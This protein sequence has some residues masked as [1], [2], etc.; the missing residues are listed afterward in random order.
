MASDSPEPTVPIPSSDRMSAPC[1]EPD[2]PLSDLPHALIKA[3]GSWHLDPALKAV[4][5]TQS[6]L[7]FLDYDGTLCPIVDRPQDAILSPSA[8]TIVR[9]TMAHVPTAI[10][11]GRDRSDVQALVGVD[12]L[13]YVGSHGFDADLP[14]HPS[15]APQVADATA[16]LDRVEEALRSSLASIDGA[17][18]ERKA[19]SIAAHY[20]LVDET[21]LSSFMKGVDAVLTHFPELTEKPGKKVR[22]LLPAVDWDKGKCVLALLDALGAADEGHCA[23][24]IGDD[25]TDEDAFRALRH[26]RPEMGGAGILVADPDDPENTD[27]RSAARWRVDS[28]DQVLCLLEVLASTVRKR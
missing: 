28:P 4:L 22:E 15:L 24:F 23:V 19:V 10:I 13:I 1:T 3:A 20:R 21:H 6:V 16:L 25:R 14:G 2:T 7:L 18:I 5:R 8:R 11:S 12:D 17:L 26:H 9:N 27:R